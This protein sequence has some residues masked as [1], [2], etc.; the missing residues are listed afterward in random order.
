MNWP[1]S[2]RT[3]TILI[4]SVQVKRLSYTKLHS[5]ICGEKSDL[6]DISTQQQIT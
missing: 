2:V 4:L 5:Q 1:G 6:D 3:G